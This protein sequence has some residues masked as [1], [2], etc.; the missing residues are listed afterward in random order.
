MDSDFLAYVNHLHYDVPQENPNNAYNYIDEKVGDKGF[1]VDRNNSDHNILTLYNNTDNLLSISH[2]GTSKGDD[3]IS[4]L[5]FGVGMEAY[6][7][8]FD[9]RKKKTKHIMMS[10]NEQQPATYLS[11][12]S[13][14]G[15]TINYTIANSPSIAKNMTEAHTFNPAVHPYNDNL[16]IENKEH[17]N[18]LNKKTT[19][20][21][22]GGDLVSKWTSSNN[23]FGKIKKYKVN[24]KNQGTFASHRLNHFSSM[25]E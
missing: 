19:H 4:D 11:G 6:N 16:K 20:H 8:Q 25:V 15:A 7:S 12:H 14:G 10:Y 13:L 22:A 9:E 23:Q 3:V 18:M 1:I 21:R 5:A 24:K 17:L 2:R